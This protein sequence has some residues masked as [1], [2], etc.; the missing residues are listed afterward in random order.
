[1]VTFD[2]FCNRRDPQRGVLRDDE[3]KAFEK[4]GHDD[5]IRDAVSSRD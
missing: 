5:G 3:T 1:V 4:R 2:T